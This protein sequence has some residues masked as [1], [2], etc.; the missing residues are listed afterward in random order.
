M[1][2]MGGVDGCAGEWSI[3]GGNSQS[4]ADATVGLGYLHHT[5]PH[6]C[7]GIRQRIF[8]GTPEQSCRTRQ[9]PCMCCVLCL[10]TPRAISLTSLETRRHHL[11]LRA[12]CMVNS[13]IR[14][15]PA[16]GAEW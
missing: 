10:Q 9:E 4:F 6:K 15:R 8:P 7:P 16:R 12:S 5:F 14:Q 1:K 13:L 11:R 3:C 2:N